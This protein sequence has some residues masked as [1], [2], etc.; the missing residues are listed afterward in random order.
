MEDEAKTKEQLINELRELRLQIAELKNSEAKLHFLQELIDAIPNPLFFKDTKGIYLGCNKSFESLLGLRKEQIVGKSVYDVSPSHLA[1]KYYEADMALLRQP[2][3]QTYES[4]VV[5]MDGTEHEMIFY[6]AT[7]RHPDGTLGGLVGTI[8]DISQRHRLEEALKESEIRLRAIIN[9]A[10]QCIKLIAADGTLLEMNPA[11]LA[12]IETNSIAQVKGKSIY[13]MIAPEY[14]DAFRML[15]GKVFKGEN[16]VLEFETIGLRG[17]HRWLSTH[18]VPF[19]DA[20]GEIVALLG[21]TDDIT[22]NRKLR[23]QL[24]QAQKM[25][26]VGQLAGGIA[27]DFNNILTAIMGYGSILRMKLRRDN[28]LIVN[29]E[30]I[31]QA[32]DKAA[33]LTQNLLAF[34]RKQIMNARPVNLNEIIAR[35][36]KFLLRI[37]GEDIEIKTNL[38]GEILTVNVDSG[39]MEQALLN[40]AT[41]ARDAMPNGGV[42]SIV[43]ELSVIND[44]F[45]KAHGFGSFGKFALISVSDTGAGMDKETSDKIFEPFFTTKDVGKGTGLGL[46][47]VYGTVKQ[48][49]GYITVY[50]EQ[51]R[52]TIFKI[53]I[54]LVSLNIE[55]EGEVASESLPVGGTETILVAEDDPVLRK[56]DSKVLTEYGYN[57]ILAEDGEDAINKFM[58]NKDKIHICILDMIMPKKSGK[59]TYEA[60]K[61]IRSDVRIIFASGY[62]AD[63][64]QKDELLEKGLNFIQKPILPNEFLKKIRAVL[65]QWPDG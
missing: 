58:D 14:H 40:L 34:S 26:A 42:L 28:Q 45:I 21:I 57:V 12:M 38:S 15:T 18:A 46:A 53:Y 33:S 36:E 2:G 35:V 13:S 60:I 23:A 5:A 16:G 64:I 37:I 63:R 51:G 30:Q 4:S 48:H 10:P 44:E 49:N 55:K 54:P 29:V 7:F 56:L 22:E 62:A 27:H 1:D 19:R 59:E 20:K 11:G 31:L 50:S 65:D 41:N 17:T 47:M 6:K 61:K 43:T 8:I 25:E 9:T 32:A 52:G 24:L 3:I 39:Q